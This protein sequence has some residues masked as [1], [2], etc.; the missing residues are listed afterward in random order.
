[1][2]LALDWNLVLAD[3]PKIIG[4][5]LGLYELLS[6]VIPTINDWTILGNII[7]FL[8]WISDYL[9]NKKKIV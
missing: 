9:N 8:K 6:R 4:F 1:M 3:L 7:K 5:I 2:L